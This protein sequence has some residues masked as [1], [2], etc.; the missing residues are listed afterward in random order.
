MRTKPRYMNAS[1]ASAVAG[2]L[3][4]TTVGLTVTTMLGGIGV[5]IL[6]LI[7]AFGVR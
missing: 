6:L 2:V 5:V 7:F 1:Y 3:I 4:A